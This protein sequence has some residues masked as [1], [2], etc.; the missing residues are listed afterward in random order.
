MSQIHL[1]NG[2]CAA[3]R[4]A[5]TTVVTT[6]DISAV[7]CKSCRNA[8]V[9]YPLDALA[10][11]VGKTVDEVMAKLKVSAPDR[12]RYRETGGVTERVADRFAA[13]FG[14]VAYEV[15]PDMLDAAIAENDALDAERRA[16]KRQRDRDRKRRLYQSDPEWREKEKERVRV[17]KAESARALRVY[18]RVY[19][20]ENHEVEKERNRRTTAAWRERKRRLGEAA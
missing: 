2:A 15:W 18:N 14:L 5:V 7:T 6:P 11:M 8:A 16:R 19:Y 20:W 13:R 3:V 1:E 12:R 9:R 4:S 10:E 17:W